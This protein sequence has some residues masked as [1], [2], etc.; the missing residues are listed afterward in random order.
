MN[1]RVLLPIL[2]LALSAAVPAGLD[3]AT[4]TT[5]PAGAIE[6]LIDREMPASGVPGLAYAVVQ[7]GEIASAGARGVLEIG[8][9]ATV[10]PDTPFVIG[11]ISKSFTALA[12]MQ[13]VEA[14]EIDLDAEIS[15]YLEVFSGRTSGA[16]TIR[17]LLSHTSG[18]STGQGNAPHPGALEE[19]DAL[20]HGVAQL[21]EATPAHEPGSTWEYSNANYEILGR[22]IEVV[23]GE[24]YQTYVTA[25]ILE[26]VGMHDSFVADGEV[27][28][29]VATGHVPWFGTKVPLA[30]GP[31]D[32]ATAPQGGIFA[33]ANDIARYLQ[34]MMND[35]DD[36]LSADGKAQMM[37]PASE[38]SSFYGFGWYLESDGAVWHTGVSPGVETLA[39]MIPAEK[40]A[41]I[42]LVN[43][44]SGMG[45]EETAALRVGVSD[46]AL[47]LDYDGGSPAWS[48]Q[49]LFLGLVTLPIVYLLSMVWAWLRRTKIRAK[50]RSGAPG[51]FSLWFPLLTT[52]A[53]A[54]VLLGLVPSLNG[55]PL[56]RWA[57]FQPDVVLAI[58]ASAVTGVIW[59]GFRLVVA[60]TG[61]PNP[62]VSETGSSTVVSDPSQPE[63]LRRT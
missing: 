34:M 21:A 45:F 63:R 20:A 42:V 57:L 11:S 18:F 60:Y 16:I 24:D 56:M 62:P 41:V 10:T 59:A 37:R 7:N 1:I 47:G 38:V 27:H 36:V 35:E 6:Q 46:T 61:R 4:P 22:L 29:P 39:T 17:Q 13:L 40:D 50:T 12:V 32:R 2:G 44:G 14:G 33:S 23:S 54:W 31:T 9:D 49:L 53:A 43:A 8:G 48:L 25:R 26:P 5:T 15:R 3:F 58:V 55:T 28:D 30:D 19:K 52:T 51:L